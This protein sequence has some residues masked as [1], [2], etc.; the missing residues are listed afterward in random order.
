M[1]IIQMN[2]LAGRTAEQKRAAVSAITDAVVATLGVKPEQVRILIHE[3]GP[4]DFAVAGETAAMRGQ[5]PPG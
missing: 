4:E 2:M 5:K 1:P 3:L